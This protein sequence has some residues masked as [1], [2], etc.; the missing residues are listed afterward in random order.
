MTSDD[1]RR[2]ST[3]LPTY[4]IPCNVR[5]FC[6]DFESPL[7]T[8]VIMYLMNVHLY[9]KLKLLHLSGKLEISYLALQ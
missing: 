2:L 7:K 5:F 6:S 1:Y 9:T 8:D 4:I 3:H